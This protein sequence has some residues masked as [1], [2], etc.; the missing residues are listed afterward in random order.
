M[1]NLPGFY[2]CA[3]ANIPF[4]LP[5]A[6]FGCQLR[7]QLRCLRGQ[8]G[9]PR[10]PPKAPRPRSPLRAGSPRARQRLSHSPPPGCRV[11]GSQRRSAPR[12]SAPRRRRADGRA[13]LFPAIWRNL[14]PTGQDFTLPGCRPAFIFTICLSLAPPSRD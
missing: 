3:L 10:P 5:A 9:R 12:R 14:P 8:G 1:E 2:A 7:C 6:P 4:A 11:G 13:C